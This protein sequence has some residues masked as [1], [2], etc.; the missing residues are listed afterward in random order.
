MYELG[1][2]HRKSVRYFIRLN[3]SDSNHYDICHCSRIT[4]LLGET[5]TRLIPDLLSAPLP[6]DIVIQWQKTIMITVRII[7]ADGLKYRRITSWISNGTRPFG[8]LILFRRH[9]WLKLFIN[10]MLNKISTK[11]YYSVNIFSFA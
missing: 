2:G 11:Y 1:K 9:V 8:V 6:S 10:S 7:Q 3:N 4:I 5:C